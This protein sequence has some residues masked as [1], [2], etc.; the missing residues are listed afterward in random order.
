MSANRKKCQKIQKDVFYRDEKYPSEKIN[1]HKR[2]HISSTGKKNIRQ[3]IHTLSTLQWIRKSDN[4]DLYTE[5]STLST[6]L[7]VEK[8]VYIVFLKNGRFVNN[9]K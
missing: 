1:L 5:L 7:T 8:V 4:S 2:N 3:N 6:F 9:D